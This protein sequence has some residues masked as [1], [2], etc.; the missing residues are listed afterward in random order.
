MSVSNRVTYYMNKLNHPHTLYLHENFHLQLDMQL[1][2][3]QDHCR[4][5]ERRGDGGEKREEN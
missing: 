2:A 1:P 4:T 5:G 3:K